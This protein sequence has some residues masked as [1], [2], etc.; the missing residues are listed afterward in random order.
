[1]AETNWRCQQQCANTPFCQSP[2]VDVLGSL[3]DEENATA[4][5][6]GTFVPPPGTPPGALKLINVLKMPELVKESGKIDFNISPEENTAAWQQIDERKG[7]VRTS[8]TLNH[9]KAWA[10]DDFLNLIDTFLCIFLLKIG[11]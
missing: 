6:N 9:H 1:M 8:L 10:M 5:R 4:I 7:S 2:L 11:F 3:V